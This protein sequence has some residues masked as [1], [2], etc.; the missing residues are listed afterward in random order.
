MLNNSLKDQIAIIFGG[1]GTIGSATAKL[2]SK[3]GIKIIVHYCYREKVARNIVD[4]I[5]KN[6]GIAKALQADITNE[7]AVKLLLKEVNKIFGRI[8]IVV[9]T[10]H[11]AFDPIL[12]N[13]MEWDDWTIHLDALK[14]HFTISKNIIPY[15]R[16]Q[17][18]GRFVFI[19]GGLSHRLHKGCSAFT[20][21]KAGLNGFCKTMAIEEGEHNITV[22]IVAPGKVISDNGNISDYDPD[23]WNEFEQEQM[24]KCPLKRYATASDVANAVL[25]F[26]SPGA[27]C[28]TG[29]TIFVT[30]GEII[31]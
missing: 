29:Q 21:I 27:S 10:V 22:N 25:Y 3:Y 28:I 24:N 12:I 15:M 5:V 11:K 18:Y 23:A 9:N 16:K 14:A 6:G 2:L 31:C 8:D 13:D 4:D 17:K 7:E 30:G 1:T 19:S 26:I 20:T